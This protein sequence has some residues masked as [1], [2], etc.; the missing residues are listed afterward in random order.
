MLH[1]YA[2]DAHG[3]PCHQS[4]SMFQ[5]PAGEQ[6]GGA[7]VSDQKVVIYDPKC[8]PPMMAIEYAAI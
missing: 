4:P 5:D 8:E 1:R 7:Y 3:F 2:R 6:R